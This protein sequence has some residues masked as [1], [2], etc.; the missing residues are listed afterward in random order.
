MIPV[1]NGMMFLL[2]FSLAFALSLLLTPLVRRLA[3][4][5]HAVDTPDQR[6]KIHA[7][8]TPR[9]G[10]V[11]IA[12]AFVVTFL[13]NFELTRPFWGLLGGL[14][15][16][17]TVGV[18]DDI[19]N[20]SAWQKLMWQVIAAAVVL[21][22]GIGIVV[23]TNPLGGTIALDIWRIPVSIGPLSFN[24]LP[25]ANTVSLLWIVGMIN[26]V[27]FLDG[28][29]GLATGVAA[30]AA[31]LLFVFAIGPVATNAVVA[32]AAIILLGSLLGFLPYNFHPARIFMG[33]SGSYVVGML[34]ALLSIY[35]ESKIAI[36]VVV[37]GFAIFDAVWT[38]ARRLI[39]KQSPFQPDRRHLHHM[40][41]DSGLFNH[42]QTVLILY[43]VALAIATA[44]LVAG[45]VWAL[46]VTAILLAGLT[47]A[48]KIHALKQ[49]SANKN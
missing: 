34:L 9:L 32:L 14:A 16:L 22:G 17:F 35:S 39:N 23:I 18:I 2:A 45:V 25:L 38:V 49:A 11:A 5:L 8:A 12:A 10:G 29:D 24:I 46:V 47:T 3:F 28:M 42:R 37:L 15:I 26:V 30:I 40:I 44:V 20:L 13:L 31:W 43:G 41:F 36:G 6:R 21:A 4:A 1:S 19:R 7:L 33:D 48:V 27:N